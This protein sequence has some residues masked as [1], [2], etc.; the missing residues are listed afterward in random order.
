MVSL[1]SQTLKDSYVNVFFSKFLLMFLFTSQVIMS[2]EMTTVAE[3]TQLPLS[4]AVIEVYG[5]N[6][7]LS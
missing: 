5:K 7:L 1:E 3:H 4:A 6:L 2:A